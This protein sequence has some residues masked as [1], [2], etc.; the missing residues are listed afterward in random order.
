MIALLALVGVLVSNSAFAADLPST[1]G[2]A[3]DELCVDEDMDG[4][5][6]NATDAA[7]VDCIDTDASAYVGALS[8]IGDGIDNDCS[9]ETDSDEKE[10]AAAL[11]AAGGEDSPK[12]IKLAEYILSC[13]ESSNEGDNTFVWALK[14]GWTCTGLPDGYSWIRGVGVLNETETHDI[15]TAQRIAGDRRA[16]AQAK[17]EAIAAAQAELGHPADLTDPANPV[18]STGLYAA[19]D[20]NL[21]AVKTA[22]GEAKTYLEEQA[23]KIRVLI[24]KAEADILVLR[25]QMKAVYERVDI[26]ESDVGDLKQSGFV[27]GF[28]GGGMFLADSPLLTGEGG[29]TVA[30]GLES[31]VT[32]GLYVGGENLHSRF[33]LDGTVEQ[34]ATESDGGTIPV[35]LFT[36]GGALS[37]RSAD[38]SV[39]GKL[40]VFGGSSGDIIAPQ[41]SHVGAVVGP[42]ASWSP[43]VA[44]G[45]CSGV[46]TFIGGGVES[47]GFDDYRTVSS[48]F[49]GNVS[50][51]LGIC[52]GAPAK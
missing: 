1:C 7:A 47:L 30:G 19:L 15:M 11:V 5:F 32:L 48:V 18:A 3:G 25:A 38:M 21:E 39:G 20:A 36:V 16:V 41:S 50:V 14:N 2:V 13:T 45:V 31:G 24:G 8:V 6:A 51:N 9:G 49:V 44:K 23:K 28:S 17:A 43:R 12:A 52:P 29:T 10:L 26:I 34:G 27:G 40:A 46:T 42:T 33:I 35:T 4:G 22:N 37:Y